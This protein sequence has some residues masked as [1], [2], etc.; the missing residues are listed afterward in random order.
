MRCIAAVLFFGI[1]CQAYAQDYAHLNGSE[2]YRR[3]CASCHGTT[4]QGDG[5]VAKHIRVE[6][7]DLTSLARRHGGTFPR[8]KVHEIID[9]RVILGA[10]GT[11]TMPVWGQEFVTARDGDPDARQAAQAAIERLTD[12]VATLQRPVGRVEP[13]TSAGSR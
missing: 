5:P 13:D 6:V 9:G 1:V 12:F 2:L 3:F 8:E 11:R 7:P 10:H 4:G